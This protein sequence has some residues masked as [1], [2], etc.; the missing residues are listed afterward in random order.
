MFQAV[1]NRYKHGQV[2]YNWEIDTKP[3]A[4]EKYN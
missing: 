3:F 1:Q 2:K 4:D